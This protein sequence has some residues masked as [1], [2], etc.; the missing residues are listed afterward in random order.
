M[1]SKKISKKIV[2]LILSKK[3]YNIKVM[4]LSKVSGIADKFIICSA[5]SDTQVKAIADEVEDK[6]KEEGIRN[7]HKEGYQTLRWVIIDYFD[8]VVHIFKNEARTYYNLEKFWAD[9]PTEIIEESL[10]EVF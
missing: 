9:A 1:E 7:F 3:G 10:K 8:V 2:E 4:D 5:D 6:L